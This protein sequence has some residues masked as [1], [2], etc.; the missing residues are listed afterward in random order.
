MAVPIDTDD[1]TH[2]LHA[3]VADM[4]ALLQE[5]GDKLKESLGDVGASL[6]SNLAQ[7]KRRLIELQ[8]DTN[9][10]LRRTARY[11]DRYAHDNPWQIT[12]AS[13][14]SGLLLGLA[15]GLAVS[16]LRG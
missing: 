9:R 2:D 15:I 10:R 7:A 5:G 1:L 14:A 8:G 11:V 12:G 3:L 13:L 4:E 16:A 6:E